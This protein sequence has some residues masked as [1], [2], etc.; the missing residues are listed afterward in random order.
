MSDTTTMFLWVGLTFVVAGFV[1]GVVGMGLPT[2]AMGVLSL[3]MPPAAAAAMLVV[4]S[5]VTNIWQL[6]AGPAFAPLLRRLATMMLAVFVGA[7]V[8]IGVLTGQSAYWAEA[9]LGA[10]LALYGAVGLA[11]PHFTVS[12]KAERWL[13]PVIGLITGLFTGATGVF[14]IPAVPYL[15]SLGLAKEELIQALGLSFTVST[16]AL[17]CALSLSGQFKFAAALNSAFA[18]VPALVGMFI[19]QR[20]RDKLP[21]ETFRKWFFAGLVVLGMYMMARLLGK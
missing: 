11:A 6:L 19:G 8:G 9:A 14:V 15:N 13:S 10:V 16:I 17:A 3:A 21:P 7:L 18:V 4:P 2:V 1:K 5:F 20:L 12:P